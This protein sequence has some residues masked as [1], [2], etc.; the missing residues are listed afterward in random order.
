MTKLTGLR[1]LTRRGLLPGLITL[2]LAL[3]LA[4][5]DWATVI[6][7]GTD[8]DDE[9]G[10]D[11]PPVA[12]QVTGFEL[13]VSDLDMSVPVYREGLGMTVVER[14]ETGSSLR[15]TLASPATPFQA[16]LTLIEF[17]DG[18]GRNLQ[19]NPGKLVFFTTDADALANRFANAGGVIHVPPADQGELGVVGFGRDP[20]KNLI[21]IAEVPQVTATF[22]S[23]VGIGVSD[24]E[25]ARDFYDFRVG[26]TERRF[27]E[28]DS[29]DEYIMGTPEGQPSLSLVLMHWTDDSEQRYRGNETRVRLVSED[30]EEVTDRTWSEE[31]EGPRD[32]DGNRLIIADEP[33][34]LE[35]A[36]TDAGPEADASTQRL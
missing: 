9:S 21:E 19:D 10:E 23:A 27:L 8:D 14:T 24:L 13:G 17:T 36:S 6:G 12:S 2:I 7:G 34:D 31:D 32:L 26:L 3:A 25:Q 18:V 20:D 1:S 4:G 29:Y 33:A 5:C 22:L 28:T 15:V 16:T 11:L 30:P 35:N